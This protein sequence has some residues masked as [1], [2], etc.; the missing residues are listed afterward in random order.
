LTRCL[1]GQWCQADRGH[2]DDEGD[3]AS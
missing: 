3:R 1:R 2:Y